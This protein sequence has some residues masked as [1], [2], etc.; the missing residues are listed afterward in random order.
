MCSSL[1]LL[2]RTRISKLKKRKKEKRRYSGGGVM[3]GCWE[4]GVVGGDWW[5]GWRGKS[6]S[7]DWSECGGTI[8]GGFFFF[9]FFFFRWVWGIV[10]LGVD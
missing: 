8:V 10:C 1:W 5:R 3:A 4:T 7:G 6:G 2:R 9:L